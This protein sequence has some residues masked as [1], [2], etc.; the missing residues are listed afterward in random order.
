M[1]KNDVKC[2]LYYLPEVYKVLES[3]AKEEKRT[4]N[5]MGCKGSNVRVISPRLFLSAVPV[6]FPIQETGT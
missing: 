1:V 4:K 5:C 6:F 2:L 3:Y